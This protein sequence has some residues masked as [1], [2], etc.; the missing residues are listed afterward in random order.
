MA[1]VFSMK[2]ACVFVGGSGTKAGTAMA[3]GCTR[4]WL[5]SKGMNPASLF[6][7]NG[8]CICQ[9]DDLE[10]SMSGVINGSVGQF[11]GAEPGMVAYVSSGAGSGIYEAT[12]VG[13]QGDSITFGGWDHGTTDT[14][15]VYVG[16]A[17][18]GLYQAMFY[19]SAYSYNCTILSNKDETITANMDLRFNGS[20]PQRNTWMRFVGY[21][22][23]LYLR[24][25]RIVSDMDAGEIYY[26]SAEQILQ[27][28]F[29][30][31]TKVTIN[32]SG[33]SGIAVS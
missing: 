31:G 20:S 7:P 8:S 27:T 32:G 13:S 29:A 11:S 15:A 18:N 22:Q 10:I 25:G 9:A 21:N 19:S 23:N 33:F 5:E 6:G 14:V 30:A 1:S 24:D 26:R 3:G 4:A 17:F 2:E 16:G 12:A 28:G